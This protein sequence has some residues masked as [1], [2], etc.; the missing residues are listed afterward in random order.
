MMRRLIHAVAY[1]LVLVMVLVGFTVAK[2]RGWLSAL[3]IDSESHDSQVV[4]AIERTQEVSL[5]SLS[6]QGIKEERRNSTIFGHK[7]PG[8]SE[9][10]FLQYQ[11]RAK[12]GID[13]SAVA[14]AQN[15]PQTFVVTV[16]EFKFI[17][18]DQPTFK[19]AAEDGGALSWVTPD[20]DKMSV[21]NQILNDDA[22][23]TYLSDNQELL[24]DQ[25]K[26]FYDRLITSIDP[27]AKTTFEFS[28]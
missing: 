26:V 13:G 10:L 6:V 15:G 21:V 5:L 23:E 18:Y 27:S 25:T 22:R 3:G 11:F 7:V 24:R 16:P 28:E 14:V 9:H 4:Q 17:G 8:T 2:D 12:L 1:L 19:V 20:I